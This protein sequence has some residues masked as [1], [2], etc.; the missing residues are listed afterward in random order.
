MLSSR[1]LKRYV[2]CKNLLLVQTGRSQRSANLT[3]ITIYSLIKMRMLI[4]CIIIITFLQILNAA[5]TGGKS[6]WLDDNCK[7]C[8][9]SNGKPCHFPFKFVFKGEVKVIKHCSCKN[10]FKIYSIKFQVFTS[11]AE[12]HLLGVDPKT[13]K[14]KVPHWDSP[15]LNKRWCSTKGVNFNLN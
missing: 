14:E 9:A 7:K 10:I 5:E 12:L 3:L 8:L 11:C 13:L 6:K 1:N 15:D 4:T 2:G